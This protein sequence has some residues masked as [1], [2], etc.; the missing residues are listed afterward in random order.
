LQ[1]A[2]EVSIAEKYRGRLLWHGT[3][4]IISMHPWMGDTVPADE[5]EHA[6]ADAEGAAGF[7]PLE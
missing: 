4:Y 3:T 5:I 1:A 6:A 2:L 7:S